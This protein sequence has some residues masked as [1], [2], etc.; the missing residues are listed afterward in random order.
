MMVSAG[1]MRRRPRWSSLV[2]RLHACR[3]A[4][5]GLNCRE[6]TGSAQQIAC[7]AGL[8]VES[9]SS[10]KCLVNHMQPR[11]DVVGSLLRPASLARSATEARAGRTDRRGVQVHRGPR[12]QRRGGPAARRWSRRRH[13]RRDAALRVLWTPGRSAR[14]LRQVRRLVDHVPR[15]SGPRR[16]G[17]ATGCRGQASLAASDE[18]RGV[19]VSPRPNDSAREGD[20][21]QRA[22]GMRPTTIRTSHGPPMPRATRISRISWTSLDA[23][24]RN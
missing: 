11:S 15:R 9:A 21:S 23:R 8:R 1:R 20:A 19:Y 4:F 17:P 7:S 16:H 18:R 14:G 3:T 12:G 10:E 6:S 2:H 24:S 22:A 13:R 5:E